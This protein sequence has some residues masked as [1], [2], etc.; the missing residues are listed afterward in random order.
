MGQFALENI[1]SMRDT[2]E[3]GAAFQLVV[4]SGREFPRAAARS[5]PRHSI[6]HPTTPHRFSSRSGGGFELEPFPG[7]REENGDVTARVWP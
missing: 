6:L 1:T 3:E 2:E 7:V 4:T 5:M